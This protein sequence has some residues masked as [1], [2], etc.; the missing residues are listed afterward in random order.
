MPGVSAFPREV[1][2]SVF[3]TIARGQAASS[4]M[5]AANGCELELIDIGLDVEG[6][7]KAMLDKSAPALN[8]S[9]D[10]HNI[11]V[12]FDS[13]VRNGSRSML[14]GPA[15]TPEECEAAMR[16]G[17]E[18]VRRASS[19]AQAPNGSSAD[20]N[21]CSN[22]T[23]PTSLNGSPAN[24]ASVAAQAPHGL[25]QSQT[26]P[27]PS[28]AAPPLLCIGELGIGNTTAAAALLAAL[29]GAS[30]IDACGRG[31]G[32]DDAG[33]RVKQE[34][35]AAALQ[36]NAALVQSGCA[37]QALQAVGGLELAAMTGACLEA[38][39]LNTPVVVD[40]FIS[41][42]AALVAVRHNPCVRRVLFLSHKSAEQGAA[43]LNSALQGCSAEYESNHPSP[44]VLDL[45]MRL[46]EGTGALLMVPLLKAACSIMNMASLADALR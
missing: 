17:A 18:A 45:G 20:I 37:L 19:P 34:A 11:T 14:A 3:K 5:C 38:E 41:G 15:M 16:A 39:K 43:I 2:F 12:V 10:A 22:V 42:A 26:Q 9:E 13:K 29:T 40:G 6:G 36:A 27:G 33:L 1:S 28:S 30:P 4:V 35:V 23:S 44:P 7:V 21:R 25:S 46:G 8:C 32:L 31:T 24:G